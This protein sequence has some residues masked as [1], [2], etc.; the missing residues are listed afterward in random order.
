MLIP[1][2]IAVVVAAFLVV[3]IILVRTVKN[4][5]LKGSKKSIAKKGSGPLYKEAEKRLAKNPHDVEALETIGDLYFQ[6]KNWEKVWNVYKTLYDISSAHPE[7]N[8]AKTT[9]RMGIAA[10]NIDKK[11]EA[12]NALMLSVRRDP[13][14]F[15]GNYYLGRSFY[16]TGAFDKAVLCLKKAKL[17]KPEATEVN[18]YLGFSLFKLQKYRDCLPY[19][20]KLLEEDPNNKEVLFDMAIAMTE[21]GMGDK[22]IKVFMHLRPDP[23]FG[24]QACVEA[25]KMHERARDYKAAIQD[26]LIGM[27]LENVPEATLL[28]IK[29]KC[30]NAY[31]QLKDI[32]S[33]LIYL[34][35]IQAY[36]S[37]YKDV[38]TLVAR[39]SE[40]NQNKNLQ[41]YLMAGT[42]DFVALCRRFITVYHSDGLVKVED[43]QVASEAVEII[44]EVDSPKWS[45]KELFRFYRNQNMIGDIYIRE[46]HSKLRDA[47]C[48]NGICVTM[49]G[50]SE[51]CHKYCEGRPIDLL[52]KNEL[53]KYLKKINMYG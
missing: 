35:Q 24:A 51:S 33:A 32:P 14:N 4:S 37:G 8:I 28:T 19:L 25:G 53:S 50:F 12:L 42:S 38:D 18:Q 10:F 40:L 22:A 11:Q 47:K 20:K 48:D 46:F 31:I 44:C 26:Y 6:D 1:I 30:A 41:T 13:E 45:A 27:K 17:L 23:Q 3:V 52:E 34:K 2:L 15:D 39:Y 29:Y 21:I 43:V 9:L 36:K 49:G 16:D 5:S 7:I